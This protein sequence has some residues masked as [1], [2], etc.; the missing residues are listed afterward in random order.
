MRKLKG[1]IYRNILEGNP[2]LS[3][4]IRN[5][6]FYLWRMRV[7]LRKFRGSDFDEH[8]IIWVNPDNITDYIGD[9]PWSRFEMRGRT[10]G[11]DWDRSAVP[12]K[13]WDVYRAMQDHFVRQKPWKNTDFYQRVVSEIE[14]SRVKWGC[15]SIAEFDERLSR[16]ESIYHDI[17]ENGY[18]HQGEISE[19]SGE[20]EDWESESPFYEYDEV[21]VCIGRNGHIL[22]RDGKHRLSIAKILELEKIPVVVGLRHE[23]W[24]DFR[25]EILRWTE[26]RGG[27][28][29]Q[30][31]THPD[32][33]DIPA[34]H[35][36]RRLELMI[37]HL[38]LTRGTL[39]DIGAFFGYFC[40]RFE[41]V[42]FRCTAV[43]NHPR[44]IYFM[45]KLRE[46]EER[47]F[48]IQDRSIFEGKGSLNYDVVL[49]LNIFHH[50]IKDRDKF[51]LFKNSLLKRI[52]A[53]IMFFES[54]CTDDYVMNDAYKNFEPDEFAQFIVDNTCFN[55][56]RQIGTVSRGRRLYMIE[57]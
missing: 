28:S 39:L 16:I 14:R 3:R 31:F 15:S 2:R 23:Q 9:L 1:V 47:D 34:Q 51:R 27:K 38:P 24:D 52:D 37:D 41:E 4:I 32:L 49:A 11:G 19:E 22:L 44:N 17:S 53:E 7:E 26:S 45:R 56:F 48:E 30:P 21:T 12:F 50:F 57:R 6:Q 8:K 36:D 18:K 29:Y 20:E 46:A 43:E 25:R 40:H 33:Q 35:D 54:H 42:G 10:E 5:I 55:R 13:G